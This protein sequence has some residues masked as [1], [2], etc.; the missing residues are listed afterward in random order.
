MIAAIGV[1]YAV[2]VGGV[3]ATGQDPG[4]VAAVIVLG[5]L[6]FAGIAIPVRR[7]VAAGWDDRDEQ[8]AREACEEVDRGP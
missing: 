8:L 7:Q 2:L 4:L 3:V 6:G 1:A 5:L